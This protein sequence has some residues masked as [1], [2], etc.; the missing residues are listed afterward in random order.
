MLCGLFGPSSGTAYVNGLNIRNSMDE[1]HLSMGLCPQFDILFD[2]LTCREHLLFYAR[3]KGI[4]ISQ[5]A[6][7]VERLL[8]AVGLSKKNLK[9]R[10]PLV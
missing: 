2:D 3:I 5:E 4:P 8:N 7:H 10:S 9:N 1:I 6:A